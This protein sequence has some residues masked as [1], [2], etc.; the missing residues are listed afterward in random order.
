M[1]TE[2]VAVL[3]TKSLRQEKSFRDHGALVV[4]IE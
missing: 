2:I 3:T 4:L 1:I